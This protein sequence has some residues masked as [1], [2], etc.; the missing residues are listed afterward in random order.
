MTRDEFLE[1][2]LDAHMAAMRELI[3]ERVRSLF[4]DG[5]IRSEADGRRIVNLQIES[6]LRGVQDACEQ[7]REV[8]RSS[9][10]E[11]E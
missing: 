8:V 9:R 4:Q 6:Y 1:N 10:R 2:L 5:I 3:E 7:F 11:A